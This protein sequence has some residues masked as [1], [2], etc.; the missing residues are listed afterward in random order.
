MCEPTFEARERTATRVGEE[1]GATLIHPFNDPRIIR[2]LFPLTCH[3]FQY[4]LLKDFVTG[5]STW[6]PLVL[7]NVYS[8]LLNCICMAVL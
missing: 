4:H 5:T 2:W 7:D 8:C 3:N 1:T 6:L